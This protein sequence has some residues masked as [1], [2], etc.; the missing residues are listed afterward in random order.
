M[1]NLGT[2]SFKFKLFRFLG[3]EPQELA[4]G[5]MESIGAQGSWS[6]RYADGRSDEGMH[7]AGDHGAAFSFFLERLRSDGVLTSLADVT[8]LGYKAVHGGSL[9][10]TFDVDDQ[11]LAE[12]ERMS[13]LAPAHNPVYLNAMRQI[14]VRFPGLRQVARFETAFHSTIPDCRTTYG[15]PYAWREAWGIRKYGFHGSSHQYIAETMAR[16]APDAGRVISCHLGGSSSL[17]AIRDGKSV[18]SSMGATP[19][20]GLFHNN[21]VGDFDVFCLPLLTQ[22]CGSLERALEALSRQS[23]L[24]GISGVSN[25]LRQVLRASQEGNQQ[26]QLAV[27]ALVDSIIGYVG[28][29]TAYLEGLDAL[30]FT[31]GIG[32]NSAVLRR[33]VC[34]RLTFLGVRLDEEK[35]NGSGDGCVSTV[36]SPVSVWRLKTNEELV[37]ARCVRAH[38]KQ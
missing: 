25:D 4:S 20:T 11:V 13:P 18:A 21:R 12:L 10:G 19:Q 34:S 3:E 14:R 22:R 27:D 1:V 33:M 23:G 28:M 6:V 38:L 31:G 36:D 8:A 30:V 17:C 29:F 16:L 2:T 9:R 26:A 35:N 15:V 5:E 32:L 37:V 24:L 7:T